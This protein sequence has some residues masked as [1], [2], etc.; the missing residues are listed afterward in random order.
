MPAHKVGA[1]GVVIMTRRISLRNQS[2]LVVVL[3][4]AAVL[5]GCVSPG[6]EN[7][8]I[9]F[10]QGDV[11]ATFQAIE[12]LPSAALRSA[13]ADKIEPSERPSDLSEMLQTWAVF[14][15]VPVPSDAI[16]LIGALNIY[17]LDRNATLLERANATAAVHQLGL[18]PELDLALAHLVLAFL[19]SERLQGE[20]IAALTPEEILFLGQDA[21][22]IQQWQL[23]TG[24]TGFD[25]YEAEAASIVEKVDIIK[26]LQAADLL[27]RAIAEVKAAS[28][29]VQ[30]PASN[31][32]P[33]EIDQDGDSAPDQVETVLGTDPNTGGDAGDLWADPEDREGTLIRSPVRSSNGV[34]LPGLL[35][36]GEDDNVITEDVH[37]LVD[38]GGNDQYLHQDFMGVRPGQDDLI[39]NQNGILIRQPRFVKVALD[40]GAGD[41]QYV[42]ETQ[43]V[44]HQRTGSSFFD[45][46][47]APSLGGASLGVAVLVDNGGSNVFRSQFELNLALNNRPL[48]STADVESL[49]YGVMQ[50][51]GLFGGVGILATFDAINDAVASVDASAKVN[52]GDQL[53]LP[54]STALGIAQGGAWLGVGVLAAFGDGAD[55]FETHTLAT[56]PGHSFGV[57]SE[58]IFMAVAQGAARGGAG[59]LLQETGS[60]SYSADAPV[61]QAS[62]WS[63]KRPDVFGGDE[64]G[65]DASTYS[66]R[67]INTFATLAVLWGGNQ[68]DEYLAHDLAQAS[69]LGAHD[70]TG[71][72]GPWF[73]YGHD[74]ELRHPLLADS[75]LED[76]TQSRWAPAV[77][78]LI[79]PGGDDKFTIKESI[80]NAAGQGAG[81]LGG[82]AL[83]LDL[84]GNDQ[85][86]SEVSKLTQ[87]AGWLG[88][89]ILL[90]QFGH[91][92]YT[93]KEKSQGYATDEPRDLLFTGVCHGLPV[94]GTRFWSTAWCTDDDAGL[95]NFGKDLEVETY[96]DV[97]SQAWIL[98]AAQI[99]TVGALVDR[100]GL[101]RYQA[102]RAA[103]GY[104]E[105]FF[106]YGAQAGICRI[107]EFAFSFPQGTYVPLA[108]GVGPTC[109]IYFPG[110]IVNGEPTS[111][112]EPNIQ[113]PPSN[114]FL[115]GLLFDA[116]NHDI[117]IY[118]INE[119]DD[120]KMPLDGDPLSRPL[121][122]NDWS[123]EQTAH[124]DRYVSDVT[125][126]D[127]TTLEPVPE[128]VKDPD[129]NL[130]A[131][132]L[133]D[134]PAIHGF[135]VD[136]E[137]TGDLTQGLPGS[138]L[139]SIVPVEIELIVTTDEDPG[140]VAVTSGKGTL[141]I[142]ATV[143][144]DD[145][146]PIQSI[147][148]LANSR[149]VAQEA[150]DEAKETYTAEW[151]TTARNGIQL[152]F[153][154]GDYWVQASAVLDFG[155]GRLATVESNP[156]L[157]SLNNP[158]VVLPEIDRN[159]VSFRNPDTFANLAVGLA[160]D[161]EAP[162]GESVPPGFYPGAYL[163]IEI[164]GPMHHV[165]QPKQ[166]FAINAEGQP[167]V[168]G[169][170]ATFSLNGMC[171][172]QSCPDGMYTVMVTAEDSGG[173][174]ATWSEGQV[175]YDG[176]APRARIIIPS[177]ASL[178]YQDG[179]QVLR[180]PWDWDNDPLNIGTV[181]DV[182]AID[183]YQIHVA[184]GQ[185]QYLTSGTSGFTKVQGISTGNVL[186]FLA[187]G[188]DVLGNTESPCGTSSVDEPVCAQA[189]LDAI[190]SINDDPC[191][192]I[193]IEYGARRTIVDFIPP[194]IDPLTAS[195]K[196]VQPGVTP[197]VYKA[198]ITDVGSGI[199]PASVRISF[200]NMVGDFP[201][202]DANGDSVY[203]F[204]KWN[205]VNDGVSADEEPYTYTVKA[206]DRAGNPVDLGKSGI[207]DNV[208][209]TIEILPTRYSLAGV[210]RQ[211]AREGARVD[212]RIIV[213]D[214][215]VSTVTADFTGVNETIGIK[216]CTYDLDT[217]ENPHDR[218]CTIFLPPNVDDGP[219]EVIV[220]ATDSAGNSFARSAPLVVSDSAVIISDVAVAE[221]GHDYAIFTWTTDQPATSRVYYGRTS[222]LG[223]SSAFNLT[224]DTNHR[225]RIDGL[226]PA[227][228]HYAVV[229]SENLAGAESRSVPVTFTSGSGLRLQFLELTEKKVLKGDSIL[230]LQLGVD[231]VD[232]SPA[233][234]VLF[235]ERT[236]GS[237]VRQRVSNVVAS[238]GNVQFSVDSTL[239]NDGPMYF[240]AQV[241]RARDV[242]EVKSPLIIIDNT[243]P[244]LAPLRPLPGDQVDSSVATFELLVF[245][246]GQGTD[247]NQKALQVLLDNAPV[248]PA[249][250][251]FGNGQLSRSLR[252]VLPPMPDGAH[253]LEIK[254]PDMAGNVGNVSLAFT[255]GQGVPDLSR[256][257]YGSYTAGRPGSAVRFILDSPA[258]LS[259][260]Q[261]DTA[262]ISSDLISLA[263]S[264]KWIGEWT[265]PDHLKTGS[266]SMSA[267]TTDV[268][269]ETSR[270]VDAFTLDVDA[271][272]PN[273]DAKLVP[274]GPAS[275]KV[276]ATSPEPVQLQILS[277][278]KL[279]HSSSKALKEHTVS[280]SG[281][282]VGKTF[283]A[284]IIATDA[285][286]NPTQ[287]TLYALLP[288]DERNPGAVTGLTARQ[289]GHEVLLSWNAA[290]DDSGIR[291]YRVERDGWSKDVQGTSV[292]DPTAFGG[293]NLMYQVTATDLV[294]NTGPKKDVAIQVK[295]LFELLQ[296]H[297]TPEIGNTTTPFD[298]RVGLRHNLPGAPDVTIIINKRPVSMTAD[299]SAADCRLECWYAAS[300][301]LPPTR[302]GSPLDLQLNVEIGAFSNSTPVQSS[303]MVV[304]STPSQDAPGVFLLLPLLAALY[305][306]RR[307][308]S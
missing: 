54:K 32:V 120:Q 30:V 261:V 302:I 201:M 193:P 270:A 52:G 234:I 158:P 79:E 140:S 144:R 254:I 145:K 141:F 129:S 280:L 298:L 265:I 246:A 271:D 308:R 55:T 142:H 67:S 43:V 102:D 245:N 57:G 136:I 276:T 290:D 49:A 208:A 75:D 149:V 281:L 250:V 181:A 91:D 164:D 172:L 148:F 2:L 306:A 153:R 257:D 115:L 121:D 106:Q 70:W 216:P 93:A 41:D 255:A 213:Q 3:T 202:T 296:V 139:A 205:Q 44:D 171:G 48:G 128:P 236:D 11:A 38:L 305:V 212:I 25:A 8:S 12:W 248:S 90:D 191:L 219:Y 279:L 24:L 259:A 283:Q 76:N 258:P 285:S 15:Q 40:L 78:L 215:E 46:A 173:D 110:Q 203:E 88:Q 206:E 105:A 175:L 263:Y 300:Q 16:S 114:G 189:K 288:V 108:K 242:V 159:Q 5:S 124:A 237:S 243:P 238:A 232:Q 26:N 179:T 233:N 127:S 177:Y 244:V 262:P 196:Y 160:Q 154:D 68:S 165:V 92:S 266:Y 204:N 13:L 183:I 29:T 222:D 307:W 260:V 95:G 174:T 87:G 84:E 42:P 200:S 143:T 210:E 282:A 227:M 169:V 289:K 163:T 58:A 284:T 59:L 47:S 301:V 132:R 130:P 66:V 51:A 292:V 214:A 31:H 85:Y 264:N 147:D 61:A 101:D 100:H 20:A 178:D 89:G 119:G 168:N 83:L 278:G 267:L 156:V 17:A 56:T 150:Y 249:S 104:A 223:L 272:P 98:F 229:A 4:S 273:L 198:K 99:P 133:P 190:C 221:T 277:E 117:Y 45:A 62:A 247:I 225:V 118:G 131:E 60:T 96:S 135:G 65:Y 80:F 209:P 109:G 103:Q 170:P 112:Q 274:T 77:A 116:D 9:P 10:V 69:A 192:G 197:V 268:Y 252:I 22:T 18:S 176:T 155:N 53:K 28:P 125:V 64:D 293:Q 81:M 235:T 126:P 188:R 299:N 122:D 239:L 73:Y 256:V 207:L 253:E 36:M 187:V 217:I 275:A 180:L 269:G 287:N 27:T 186:S 74:R 224:P 218:L 286:G 295:D 39:R 97:T 94:D 82:L 185:I 241:F 72:D 111:W 199:N 33:S 71:D 6:P 19:E 304:Q 23:R 184:D 14:D 138:F 35:I 167:I 240:V 228:N 137:L 291:S 1:R 226:P 230:S 251:T 134:S 194:R 50:G 182:D 231:G 37:F 151:D 86:E 195:H 220:K 294:G 63:L 113:A 157:V 123:W 34:G 166:Y 303:V 162:P 161:L 107:D 152:M 7:H 21:E 146:I 297:V 211:A